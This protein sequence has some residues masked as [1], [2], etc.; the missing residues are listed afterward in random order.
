MVLVSWERQ[1]LTGRGVVEWNF[2]LDDSRSV[3]EKARVWAMVAIAPQALSLP[4]LD[5]N[6]GHFAD[7]ERQVKL[8][9]DM[10]LNRPGAIE[11]W[12]TDSFLRFNEKP[13]K[14][15]FNDFSRE[16]WERVTIPGPDAETFIQARIEGWIT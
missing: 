7:D 3:D 8:A 9:H 6:S 14:R 13:V 1:K 11:K 2:P 5:I 15:A 4:D 16:L 10:V 12:R